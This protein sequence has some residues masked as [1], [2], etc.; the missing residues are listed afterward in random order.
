MGMPR[1]SNQL[2]APNVDRRT[3]GI[4]SATNIKQMYMKGHMEKS[5]KT[6]KQAQRESRCY[7]D[8]NITPIYGISIHKTK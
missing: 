6:L 2:S 4:D 3:D 8:W 5:H 1:Q 7:K